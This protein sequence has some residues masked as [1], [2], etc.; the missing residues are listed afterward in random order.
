MKTIALKKY[1]LLDAYRTAPSNI[2][3]IKLAMR[4]AG[5]LGDSLYGSEAFDAVVIGDDPIAAMVLALSL[6][7]AGGRVLIS[8]DSVGTQDW[9]SRDWGYQLA[10]TVNAFDEDV[11]DLVASQVA[12]FE[13]RDGYMKALSLLIKECAGS[14][15]ILILHSDKLQSSHGVIKGGRD[16]TFFP[17]RRES[18]HHPLINPLWRLVREKVKKLVF[19]HAEIEY[20]SA[21]KLFITTPA[22]RY[23]N[24]QLGTLVGLAREG[25]PGV[26]RRDRADDVHSAATQLLRSL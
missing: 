5:T 13:H 17:L 23:I 11:A 10:Q 8:P 1:R 20:V 16:L 14:E 9:P 19:N 2:G 7:R 18:Q 26:I 24:P 12:N 22:S 6:E 25:E 4:M 3:L 15:Q 21:R